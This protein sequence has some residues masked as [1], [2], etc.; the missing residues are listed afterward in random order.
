MQEELRSLSTRSKRIV[1]KGSG[2][3]VEV[4]RP[5]LVITAIQE[6]VR[7]AGGSVPSETNAQTVYK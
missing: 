4:Y 3:Y 6:I 5:D 2:H 7:D 1:A